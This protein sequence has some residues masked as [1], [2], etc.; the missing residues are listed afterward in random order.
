MLARLLVRAIFGAL[1]LWL[2]A[3]IVPGVHVRDTETLILAAVILGLV[4]A[5]V[6]PIVVILTLPITI[7]TLGLFLLI[8]NAGLI[9]LVSKFLPG[10]SVHGLVAGIEAAIV[11]GVV[12]WIG[13]AVVRS[14]RY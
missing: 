14:N 5:F 10:F 4:N 2:A 3:R 7:I 11:T 6:R 13:H 1:G 9:L 12:S 8:V